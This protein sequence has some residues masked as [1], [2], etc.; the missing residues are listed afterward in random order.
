MLPEVLLLIPGFL[1]LKALFPPLLLMSCL[2]KIKKLFRYLSNR[3]TRSHLHGLPWW[4][5]IK[6]KSACQG[7]R[8]RRLAYNPRGQEDSPG[9]GNGNPLWYS[10]LGNPMNR[11]TW[12]A[13]PSMGSQRVGHDLVTQKQQ[14]LLHTND[15]HS[16]S[17]FVS[18]IRSSKSNKVS[19][20]TQ[21]TQL[22]ILCY[23]AQY[24]NAFHTNNT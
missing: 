24:S 4:L 18:P 14:S 1:F 7:R 22:V 11:A 21:L 8:Y 16:E 5:N 20:D 10:C 6:N 15:F 2:L 9:G 3:T 13:T 19:L 17:A 12:W 23:W